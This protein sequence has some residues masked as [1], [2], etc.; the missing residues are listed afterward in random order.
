MVFVA[1]A[2]LATSLAAQSV[3]ITTL[4][5]APLIERGRDAQLLNFD[6]VLQNKTKEKLDIRTVEVSVFDDAGKLV[7]QKRVGA[8]GMSVLTIPNRIVDPE[9]SIIVFNPLY[10]FDRA[11]KLARMQY[12]FV[13][14]SGDEEE[15]YR[16][17]V[18]VTPRPYDKGT[19]VMPVTGRILIH[20]GHD[21]YAHHRRLDVSGPMTTALGIKT[22][23]TRYAYDFCVI[24]DE[25]K[26]YRGDGEKNEDWY[27]FGT[28]LYAPAAGRVVDAADGVAD[29]TKSKKNFVMTPESFMKNPKSFFGNFV[30]IEH[31]SGEFSLLAHLKQG[32]VRVKKGDTVKSGQE[33]GQMGM[34]GDA[35]LVHLHYQLQSDA[36]WGEGVPSYFRDFDL[37]TGGKVQHFDQG[38]ID[39][40]DV[41]LVKKR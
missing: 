5:A 15:K 34:S 40:G 7:A 35:F 18:N 41:L 20:D 28:P 19:L 17:T 10:S 21:F 32:S 16:T 4:P 22:N 12:E 27:G 11:L 23:L 3:Q 29:N 24:D 38:Q 26:T 33:L 37:V 13:F 31:P 6:F 30:M 25:G 39:S 9:G 1:A 36:A 8:N 2:L 14:D